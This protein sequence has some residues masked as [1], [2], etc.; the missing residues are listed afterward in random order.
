MLTISRLRRGSW[1]GSGRQ[2]GVAVI[3][4]GC[5]QMFDPTADPG[6]K[7]MRWYATAMHKVPRR[8]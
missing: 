2:H 5:P 1:P 7:V 8:V 3:D 4:G 6:H